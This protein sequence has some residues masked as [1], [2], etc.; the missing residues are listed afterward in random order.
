MIVVIRHLLICGLVQ[1]VGF[2]YGFHAAATAAGVTGWVR[3]R[4]DGRVE[5]VIQGTPGQLDAVLRWA[6]RGPPGARVDDV[7]DTEA[8]GDL[9]MAYARFELRPTA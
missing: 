6:R 5:A 9:A 7:V 4:R 2:R 1:G 3:N 8:S